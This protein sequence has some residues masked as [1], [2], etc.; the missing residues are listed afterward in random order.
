MIPWTRYPN[1]KAE[2]AEV[3]GFILEAHANGSWVVRHHANA[4]VSRT[5][6]FEPVINPGADLD[7]AKA[8]AEEAFSTMMREVKPGA[9]Q[10][11]ACR[12]REITVRLCQRYEQIRHAQRRL[13]EGP[14]SLEAENDTSALEDAL[15]RDVRKY[16]EKIETPVRA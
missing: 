14:A 9:Q 8:K 4:V 1:I 10:P 12:E 5:S 15:D 7:S 6:L 3:G 13:L 2:Y 11:D 16:L